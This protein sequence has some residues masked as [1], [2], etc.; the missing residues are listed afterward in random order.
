MV[1]PIINTLKRLAYC[2]NRTNFRRYY[3]KV[4][5]NIISKDSLIANI[6]A[7]A[8]LMKKLLAMQIPIL[9]QWHSHMDDRFKYVF[10]NI[11]V[12]VW[13]YCMSW[14]LLGTKRECESKSFSGFKANL[15]RFDTTTSGIILSYWLRQPNKFG[16]PPG[17]GE[18]TW[19]RKRKF[20]RLQCQPSQV[21][22]FRL[23]GV[24]QW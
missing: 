22:T 1:D 18:E 24:A 16:V 5:T 8:K 2:T 6:I 15:P 3:S 20:L 23:K 21:Q 12:N 17:H 14:Q 10:A 7:M 9:F 4:M 19:M 13:S 11:K